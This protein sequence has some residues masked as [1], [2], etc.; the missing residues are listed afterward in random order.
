MQVR[1]QTLFK[2]A[3]AIS[4]VGDKKR[5]LESKLKKYDGVRYVR[6]CRADLGRTHRNLEEVKRQNALDALG[7]TGRIAAGICTA[8]ITEL[9]AAASQNAAIAEAE[10][11]VNRAIDAYIRAK[12]EHSVWDDKKIDPSQEELDL[13]RE[14]GIVS[15]KY[16]EL[17]K[18]RSDTVHLHGNFYDMAN[19]QGL[20]A[21]N[22]G[23][24][25]NH[26]N[27][28]YR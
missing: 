4:L 12:I 15:D 22:V 2:R 13:E 19:N 27:M 26:G 10:A 28:Q 7:K 25:A 17:L 14:L 18:N 3:D 21:N 9:A 23:A 20:I 11:S 5:M 24:F 1:D 16:E 8:G 6:K